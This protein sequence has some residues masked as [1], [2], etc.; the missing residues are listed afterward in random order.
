MIE[1]K[2]VLDSIVAKGPRLTTF[3]L[4][5]HRYIHGELM[6]HRVFSRNASSSRAIPVMKVLRQV[7]NDPAIPVHWGQ[8]QPGMQADNQLSGWRKA[9]ARGLWRLAGKSACVMAYAMMRVGLH[10]QVANRI[11]EPWQFIHVVLSAT[12]LNNW[13][14]LRDH[15]DAQPE[16]RVLAREMGKALAVS[17]PNTLAKGQWHLPYLS[18]SEKRLLSTED[19]R[20]VSAARCCRV[21]YLKHDGTESNVEEDIQLC[22]RLAGSVP[23]HASPFEHVAT[24]L[25]DKRA[26]SGNFRGWKQYRKIIERELRE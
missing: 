18:E 25:D 10:K 13:F 22:E 8:N 7:W 23:I 26:W 2:V 1:A 9:A 17:R 24:P 3:Q 6:T 14:A 20:K 11:L 19:A 15:K 5:Y 21:S 16:I 4:K 12:E